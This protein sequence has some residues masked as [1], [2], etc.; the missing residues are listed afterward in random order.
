MIQTSQRTS[1][2]NSLVEMINSTYVKPETMIDHFKKLKIAAFFEERILNGKSSADAAK[3]VDSSLATIKRYKKDQGFKP[4]RKQKPKT[5]EQKRQIYN[6]GAF[7]KMRNKEIKEKYDKIKNNNELSV[8]EKQ[9]QIKNL[10]NS[11]NVKLLEFENNGTDSPMSDNVLASLSNDNTNKNLKKNR[12]KTDTEL[13]GK[14]KSS[15]ISN[16]Q[17]KA[18]YSHP[19]QKQERLDDIILQQGL[20]ILKQ[21]EQ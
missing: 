3:A 12:Y 8:N 13:T 21:D 19:D 18:V 17:D 1:T 15:S 4:E 7:T 11:Y 10:E 2:P 14:G 16:T 20:E 5:L 9:D 6:K